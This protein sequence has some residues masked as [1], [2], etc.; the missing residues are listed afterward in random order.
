MPRHAR[1]THTLEREREGVRNIKE[2]EGGVST[3][4]TKNQEV[5][6]KFSSRSL[7]QGL[8]LLFE[9]NIPHSLVGDKT[10]I[11]SSEHTAVF[12]ALKPTIS[13]VLSA[14]DLPPEEIAQLRREN[15][16][17]HDANG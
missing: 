15:L 8:T 4:H 11:L 2:K 3:Q 13:E 10:V 16:S 1:E 14:G 7:R 9:H 12:K 6:L 17:F 5:A